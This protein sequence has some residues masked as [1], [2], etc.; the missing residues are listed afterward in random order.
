[1]T[2][3]QKLYQEHPKYVS[4]KYEGGCKSCPD[5]YGYEAFSPCDKLNANCRECW[6][7]EIPKEDEA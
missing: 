1:M 7:R 5:D 3:A 2:F 6:C 4:S